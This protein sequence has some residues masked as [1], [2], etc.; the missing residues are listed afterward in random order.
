MVT[1]RGYKLNSYCRNLFVPLSMG[2]HWSSIF[3]LDN[4]LILRLA[5][6]YV[7][8]TKPV[9][10]FTI[11]D[12]DIKSEFDIPSTS[13]DGLLLLLSKYVQ[14]FSDKSSCDH[15]D[16]DNYSGTT[17]VT[18]T[19]LTC[20]RWDS[21]SPHSHSYTATDFPDANLA[22][23]SN[24]CRGIDGGHWPWCFTTDSNIR[25]EYCKLPDNPCRKQGQSHIL[26]KTCYYPLDLMKMK[27]LYIIL[28]KYI[29]LLEAAYALI[30]AFANIYMMMRTNNSTV[31]LKTNI[32]TLF[33]NM[34]PP[35][36][37]V[38]ARKT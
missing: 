31:S 23:A 3:S 13:A 30:H 38:S 34:G 16:V 32:Q 15:I 37:W 22:A 14:L 5:L 21:Y 18:D 10:S 7:N 20:Q 6:T 1:R 19:G 35:Y 24:Y 17:S 36:R 27:I 9:T 28:C 29:T 8:H 25:W 12:E 26:N 4:N 11:Q 33:V 2:D